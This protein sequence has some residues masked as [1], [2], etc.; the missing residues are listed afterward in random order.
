M[1]STRTPLAA[2]AAEDPFDDGAVEGVEQDMYLVFVANGQEYA[3]QAMKVQEISAVISVT[4]IPRA[5][6]YIEGILN[7][8]GR[9]VTV[10]NFRRRFG[11]ESVAPTEDTRIIIMDYES[12]PVGL[13]VDRVEEVLRIPAESMR[14]LPESAIAA[15]AA[16]FVSGIGMLDDRLIVLLNVGRLVTTTEGLDLESMRKAGT[17]LSAA[18][19]PL[20]E[21]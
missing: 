14:A 3:I 19:L 4:Q 8:R 18:A 7:L 5:P 21:A 16:D 15:G 17:A 10:I 1:E 12:F 9:L 2:T 13:I 20:V 11:L 6:V